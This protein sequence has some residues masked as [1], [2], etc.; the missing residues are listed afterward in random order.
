M[1]VWTLPHIKCRGV[2]VGVLHVD[3][4]N[5]ARVEP[6]APVPLGV[7]AHEPRA[8]QRHSAVAICGFQPQLNAILLIMQRCMDLPGRPLD[9]PI[10]FMGPLRLLGLRMQRGPAS[11]AGLWLC[12]CCLQPGVD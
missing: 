10:L 9:P 4:A 8:D 5:A 1:R 11:R 2:F 12:C 7:L 6:L 3:H